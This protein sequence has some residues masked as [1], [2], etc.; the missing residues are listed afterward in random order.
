MNYEFEFIDS[1]IHSFIHF[2]SCVLCSP[3]S[4]FRFQFQTIRF[5]PAEENR[6]NTGHVIRHKINS[7]NYLHEN[8]NAA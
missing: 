7:K 3:V 6:E 8:A 2:V 5:V 4:D 1:F